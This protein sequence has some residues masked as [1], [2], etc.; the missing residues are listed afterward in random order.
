MGDATFNCRLHCLTQPAINDMSS[1]SHGYCI[2]MSLQC[3][4]KQ[5]HA[6]RVFVLKNTYLRGPRYFI[7]KPVEWLVAGKLSI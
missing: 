7:L 3:T 4:E 2:Y 6:Y 1:T 5:K